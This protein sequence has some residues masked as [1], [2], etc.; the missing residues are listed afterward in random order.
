VYDLNYLV[1]S[2]L[3]I[4]NF[5][6]GHL[7]ELKRKTLTS[8]NNFTSFNAYDVPDHVWAKIPGLRKYPHKE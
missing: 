7:N 5:K 8:E 6:H 2:N 3:I 4:S 1:L